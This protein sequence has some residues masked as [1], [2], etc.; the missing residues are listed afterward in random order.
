[1][2]VSNTKEVQ[3]ETLVKSFPKD[4]GV[5]EGRLYKYTGKNNEI[6]IPEG[7][8]CIT[9]NA[10]RGHERTLKKIIFPSTLSKLE[11][12]AFC[13]FYSLQE[14]VFQDGLKEIGKSVFSDCAS[15]AQVSLPKTLQKIGIS[16]FAN[17]KEIR[18]L[19]IP[20]DL[21][22]I[23]DSAFQGCYGLKEIH[24]PATLV[25][26]GKGVFTGTRVD[27]YN[28]SKVVDAS[29]SF[30]AGVGGPRILVNGDY[31]AQFYANK[32]NE[33]CGLDEA[34]G[35]LECIANQQIINENERAWRTQLLEK[36]RS[37]GF[38]YFLHTTN[39]GNFIQ[40]YKMKYLIPRSYLK[41]LGISFEDNAD[42]EIISYTKS[43][44]LKCN[45]FYYRPKTP[46]N[47]S[48]F[49]C[50]G[51]TR[52]VILAFQEDLLY[53]PKVMFC[54][55]NAR[56]F[57]SRLE[58][59]AKQALG[60]LWDCVFNMS[61]HFLENAENQS[62]CLKY[63]ISNEGLKRRQQAEFLYPGSISIDKVAK[64][65]FRTQEDLDEARRILG[66]DSRFELKKEYFF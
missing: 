64:F 56:A 53:G 49:F 52:P 35:S 27:I 47:Y 6:K 7:V 62:L 37:F 50:H 44:I 14:C 43:E 29:I 51:Q 25:E 42:P 41:Q 48:A 15:L 9:R 31:V 21:E 57:P 18:N 12:S 39:F 55:G 32:K 3:R 38:Q 59:S 36:M 10:F 60:F 19:E 13:G 20:N 8:S 23:G 22:S 40:I 45:R 66:D 5:C 16:A 4:F 17:C 58:R 28:Y 34:K 46:T 1:M 65:Y 30:S 2:K 24:L 54:D 11:D 26:L 33:E 61:P 63:S